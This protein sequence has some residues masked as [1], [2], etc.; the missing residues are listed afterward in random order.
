MQLYHVS[1]FKNFKLLKQF[2]L[3]MPVPSTG[4][5]VGLD[6]T[7]SGSDSETGSA[8][9][10]VVSWACCWRPAVLVPEPRA[11]PRAGEP[12]T[13][14]TL[15]PCGQTEIVGEPRFAKR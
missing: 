2:I 6:A 4:S 12:A 11:L 10:G 1:R 13:T 7:G 9:G 3:R 8:S 14:E 5:E 15:R